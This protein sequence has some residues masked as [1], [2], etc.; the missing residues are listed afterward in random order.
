M[1][2]DIMNKI[3]HFKD[4]EDKA[5][6]VKSNGMFLNGIIT[7]SNESLLRIDDSKLGI[8]VVF[9]SDIVTLD[10]YKNK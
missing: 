5:H 1:N 10:F 4:S 8:M 3:K 9:L 7:E 2:N 6:L